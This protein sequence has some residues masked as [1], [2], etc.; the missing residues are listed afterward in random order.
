MRLEELRLAEIRPAELR[1]AEV[2]L[3]EVRPYNSVAFKPQPPFI[4]RRYSLTDEVKLT[5][6]AMKNTLSQRVRNG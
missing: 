3:A 1:P 6:S 4:P 2:R 5:E